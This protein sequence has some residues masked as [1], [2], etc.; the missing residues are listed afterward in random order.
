MLLANCIDRCA[1]ATQGLFGGSAGLHRRTRLVQDGTLLVYQSGGNLGAANV[2]SDVNLRRFGHWC[3]VDSSVILRYA[4]NGGW[5]QQIPRSPAAAG[6]L[7]MT[8][9]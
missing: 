6:D 5:E 8:K 9:M 7:V 4:I 1:Y 3:S 2:D